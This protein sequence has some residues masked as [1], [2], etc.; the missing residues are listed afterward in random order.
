VFPDDYIRWR[1]GAERVSSSLSR[2]QFLSKELIPFHSREI[3]QYVAISLHG[4]SLRESYTWV[5]IRRAICGKKASLLQLRLE[6]L[7]HGC[8][9]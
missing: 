8:A 7:H 1:Y 3:V 6:C 4:D 9:A 2:V 5:S